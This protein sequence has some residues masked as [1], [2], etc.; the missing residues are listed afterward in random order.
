MEAGP[1]FCRT[2]PAEWKPEYKDRA[3]KHAQELAALG[4]DPR[5]LP[6]VPEYS[7]KR[8]EL[9]VSSHW[10]NFID[11]VRSRETPRC[12]V[13]RA[14]EEA[15]TICLSVEAFKRSAK[16]RWDPASEAIVNA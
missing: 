2:Y 6:A 5:D 13:D 8:D 15:A 16:V 3:A 4:Y 10:Q 7:M 14:F 12:G 1:S 9:Q 11:C